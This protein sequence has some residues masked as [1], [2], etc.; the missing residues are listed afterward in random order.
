MHGISIPTSEIPAIIDELPILTVAGVFAT[1]SFSFRKASELR[2][3]ETDRIMALVKNL[4]NCKVD[5]QEFEDGLSVAGNPN[6]VLMGSVDSFQDHRIA[7]SFHIA[8]LISQYNAKCS[9]K[10]IKNT[11]QIKKDNWI[12]TSFPDFFDKVQYIKNNS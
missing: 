9:N 4:R 8:N 7:M 2:K 11:I 6:N 10:S 1:G 3:K 5:V 12:S